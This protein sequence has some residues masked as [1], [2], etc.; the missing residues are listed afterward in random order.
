M[1]YTLEKL[2][3]V[4]KDLFKS[5]K[6]L[7]PLFVSLTVVVVK[8]GFKSRS[9]YWLVM[10]VGSVE[11]IHGTVQTW[12]DGR[13]KEVRHGLLKKLQILW[14]TKDDFVVQRTH[15]FHFLNAR[16]G[17]GSRPS[18]QGTKTT[19]SFYVW[20]DQILSFNKVYTSDRS[21]S[22]LHTR[23][24]FWSNL[25]IYRL[26]RWRPANPFGS[27]HP[28]GLFFA[29]AAALWARGCWTESG[30]HTEGGR[31]GPEGGNAAQ[32]ACWGERRS[33]ESQENGTVIRSLQAITDQMIGWV[34]RQTH[35]LVDTIWSLSHKVYEHMMFV[36]VCLYGLKLLASIKI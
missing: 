31:R 32:G 5:I 10:D 16:R 14:F 7:I 3:C 6:T 18:L 34:M 8:S 2:D 33:V 11:I 13:G 25:G 35:I 1:N 23:E 22:V 26:F 12:E 20:D 30:F 24:D 15:L 27:A 36:F 19:S 4:L 21:Y 17:T 9:H 29:P 28:W